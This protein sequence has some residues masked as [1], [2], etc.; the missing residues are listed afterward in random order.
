[1]EK[2]PLPSKW[3]C[4]IGN[5]GFW[6]ILLGA[7]IRLFAWVQ[8]YVINPDGTLYIHQARALY[9]G[10]WKQAT[11]CGTGFLSNY[12]FLITAAFPLFGDWVQAAR[13]VS[14]LFGTLTLV[15]LYF[16]LRRFFT[17]SVSALGI[18]VFAVMP[19]LA[20]R[21]AD[22]VRDPVYWFFLVLGMYTFVARKPT[23]GYQ[24][25]LLSSLSFLLATWARVE[26]MTAIFVSVI[27][28]IIAEREA[29]IKKLAIFL[30]PVIGAAGISFIAAWTY[31]LPPSGLYRAHEIIDKASGPISHY[32]MLRFNLADLGSGIQ[33][34]LV[35]RFLP[36]ASNFGWLVGLGTF[37]NRALEAFFYPLF[38][39][40]LVGVVQ[41]K[42]YL[43]KEPV[44]L[45]FILMIVVA[46]GG[47]YLHIL[48]WWILDNRHMAII[49]FPGAVFAGLGVQRIRHFLRSRFCLNDRA[50]LWIIFAV[51]LVFT[52][53]KNL[54][55]REKDKEVFKEIGETV[56]R[57]SG[58]REEIRV[59]ASMDTIR[60]FSFYANLKFPG[61]PCPQPYNDFHA[62]VGDSYEAFLSNLKSMGVRYFLWEERHWP[63]DR[64]D[65]FQKGYKKDFKKIGRWKHRDTGRMILFEL[66]SR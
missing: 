29:R 24:G 35:K 25:L 17:E 27:Y 30:I 32:K 28:L 36:E 60:W 14:F 18:L 20:G 5:P 38:A 12:A 26:A 19:V 31:G 10:L 1:M 42:T 47:L 62:L 46:A 43:K 3:R 39:L 22:V 44:L 48:Q 57:I 15:P 6:V 51:I 21:S 64:Y 54:Q 33:D 52:L 2:P 23:T 55:P 16:L 59:A 49:I 4:L 53:P 45:Y 56:A 34:P 7:G 66:R 40:F 50:A 11:P 65:F 9:Y 13:A 41:I 61:A 37:A 63:K 58:N 8:T